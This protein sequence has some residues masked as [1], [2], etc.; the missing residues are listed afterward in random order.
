MLEG[1]VK[2]VFKIRY[3]G[4]S[5]PESLQI[6]SQIDKSFWSRECPDI[7]LNIT[8]SIS[9]KIF[10]YGIYICIGRLNRFIFL[11]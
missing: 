11:I 8:W 7:W 1:V 5:T 3:V 6:D 9:M 10:L 4:F 2:E